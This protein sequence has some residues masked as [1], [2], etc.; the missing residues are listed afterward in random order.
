MPIVRMPDGT[1]VRFPDEMPKEQIRDMI[2]TKFPEVAPKTETKPSD[3]QMPKVDVPQYSGWDIAG[4]AVKGFGKGVGV[5]LER[6]LS[7]L[8]LG[9]YDW[10]SDKLGLGSRE[11]AEELKQSGGT[12]MKVAL[13]G[14]EFVGGM[15]PITK[16]ASVLK[17]VG[18]M[19]L[20]GA[21]AGALSSGFASDFD[22]TQ[23]AVGGTVG[24][25][26]SGTLGLAGKGISK[27]LGKRSAV[28]GVKRG[29]E[30]AVESD[31]GT[32]ILSTA[33]GTNKKI[34][35]EVL[36]KAPEALEEINVRASRALDK[37]LG[38]RVNVS[39][40]MAKAKQAYADFIEKNKASQVISNPSKERLSG[41]PAESTF[42]IR[43][44]SKKI[45]IEKLLDR[46]NKSGIDL[47]GN[48]DHFITKRGRGKYVR[49]LSNT[50][51][52]PD[53][54][55]SYDGKNYKIKKYDGVYNS[56][57][58]PFF[59]FIVEKDGKIYNKFV[60]DNINYISNQIKKPTQNMS[61]S[62]RI[63]GV[64]GTY[65]LPASNYSLSYLQTN[66]KP[67]LS[68][69]DLGIKDLT[70]QQNEWL[71]QAWK[72]GLKN[73]NEKAGSLGHLDEMSKSLN[74]MISNSMKPS[75][76]GVGMQASKQT[77]RLQVIKD[78]LDDIITNAG[79][80]DVKN[81]YARAKG[82]QN[83]YD[84]GLKFNPNDVKMRNLDFNPDERS[85][86]A[87]GL[88]EKIRMNPENKNIAGN[89]KSV[90][91][92]LRKVLGENA[93]ATLKELEGLDKSYGRI[94]GLGKK[95]LTK[96]NREDTAGLFLREQA[97][98]RGSLYGTIADYAKGAL[99]GNRARGAAEYLLNPTKKLRPSRYE[100]FVKPTL[101]E[102]LS[103][104]APKLN[105]A[106]QGE[107]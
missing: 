3:V 16:G 81:Q 102:I 105:R 70:E 39:D 21:G 26:L 82:L 40:E 10:A 17:G 7:G 88:V 11:R 48:V 37:G 55:Y 52:K 36:D 34:A 8:T 85:A 89:V 56:N 20:T 9:G 94:V 73:T 98:S 18:G 99:T 23:M 59:D 61:L 63:T 42:N 97:E 86:F 83:A 96:T 75:N 60:P 53:I 29:L 57:K 25:A 41:Y 30:N 62:G 28:K 43:D 66:V 45:K 58:E 64:E 2:A 51:E 84:M 50:L 22:P 13:G 69:E 100:Y 80:K 5:G 77:Q 90:K 31:K 38:K 47:D 107:E 95:A 106:I 12:P 15:L 6:V 72:D 65:P 27:A 32:G 4:S 101:M 46:A 14:T 76:T 74:D 54:S 92:A 93:D 33:V 91:G 104:E 44:E 35:N 67:K 87:Q 19:A 79:L 24:G 103:V 49:T 1:Q 78:K 71:N 68:A